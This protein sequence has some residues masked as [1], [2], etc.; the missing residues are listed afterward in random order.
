MATNVAELQCLKMPLSMA[1]DRSTLVYYIET[2]LKIDFRA[3]AKLHPETFKAAPMIN[4]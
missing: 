1:I 2:G 3:S 4:L